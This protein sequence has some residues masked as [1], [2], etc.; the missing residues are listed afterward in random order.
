MAG[1]LADPLA[2]TGSLTLIARCPDGSSVDDPV[3][4]AMRAAPSALTSST[5]AFAATGRR[6]RSGSAKIPMPVCS[7]RAPSGYA[8]STRRS[9]PSPA[10][11]IRTTHRP[12]SSG[13]PTATT[14]GSTETTRL[15]RRRDIDRAIVASPDLLEP[16]G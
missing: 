2:A 1:S 3:V 10:A 5:R 9:R 16:D 6:L 11:R 12:G 8:I 15:E 4:S 7:S 13:F 14:L